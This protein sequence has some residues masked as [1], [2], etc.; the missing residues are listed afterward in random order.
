[1][2]CGSIGFLGVEARQEQ[3][4]PLRDCRGNEAYQRHVRIHL[5]LKVALRV[6]GTHRHAAKIGSKAF[7]FGCFI[8]EWGPSRGSGAAS[9]GGDIAQRPGITLMEVIGND[10]DF[11]AALLEAEGVAVVQG[12]AFGLGPNFRISY[13]TA[14]AVLEDACAKIQRFCA[15]LA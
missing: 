12:A 15:S 9:S 14:T 8:R 7:V 10:E 6:Q 13:A 3:V 1:L 2:R 4:H 11:V 5:C